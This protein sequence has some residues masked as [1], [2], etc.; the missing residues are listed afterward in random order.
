MGRRAPRPVLQQRAQATLEALVTAG[1]L[2][3]D[4]RAPHTVAVEEILAR[5]G[6]SASSFHQRFGSKERFFMWWCRS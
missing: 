6:A 1:E 2:L 4:G 5:A 3:L